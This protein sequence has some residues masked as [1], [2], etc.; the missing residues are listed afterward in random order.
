MKRVEVEI[1]L[2]R[3]RCIDEADKAG[4]SEPDMWTVFFKVD[5]TTCVFS[6]QAVITGKAR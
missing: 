6:E 3:L 1:D 2:G 5:G 4:N